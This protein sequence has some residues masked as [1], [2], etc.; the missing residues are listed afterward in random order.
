MIRAKDSITHKEAFFSSYLVALTLQS[1]MKVERSKALVSCSVVPSYGLG[2]ITN[3]E[4]K[5]Q[6]FRTGQVD[7]KKSLKMDDSRL[8]NTLES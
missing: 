1:T 6:E 3:T 7:P 5:C 8:F 2:C 4:K